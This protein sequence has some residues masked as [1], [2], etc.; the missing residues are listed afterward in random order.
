MSSTNN[1][2]LIIVV[3]DGQS[4]NGED[5]VRAAFRAWQAGI[6][7]SAVGIPDSGK[8]GEKGREEVQR[9]AAAGGGECHFTA[10]G[11]LAYTVHTITM[12]AV[13]TYAE[14]MTNRHLRQIVGVELKSLPPVLR[15]EILPVVG[16]L[17]EKVPINL[18]LLIDTSGSMKHKRDALQRSIGDL[19]IS[20]AGRRGPVNLGI[21]R[22][23][24][25]KSVADILKQPEWDNALT[26]LLL[27]SLSFGGLTP[28]GPAI[29]AAA[30]ALICPGCG[31][32][33][34]VRDVI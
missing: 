28:T 30:K 33:K 27:Q 4:N 3:T 5:P 11:D 18:M 14:H 24:G 31:T 13:R 12:E 32:G 26:S 2:N 16:H 1:F 15:N 19:L 23:P 22:F 17:E 25:K 9:I 20:L 29:E 6:T 34:P 8:L 10:A 21:I 7:V